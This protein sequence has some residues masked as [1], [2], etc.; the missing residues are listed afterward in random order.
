MG[1]RCRNERGAGAGGRGAVGRRRQGRG[2]RPAALIVDGTGC[3]G[4]VPGVLRG[5][6]RERA[7]TGG[8]RAGGG[9]VSRV[10]RGARPRPRGGLAAP[11]RRLHPD[12]PRIGPDRQ[13]APGRDPHALRLAR[14][15]P[16]PPREP[17]GRGA[18]TEARRH[19]GLDAGPLAGGGEAAPRQHRPRHPGRAPGPGAAQRHALQLR[20]GE[21]G[22]GDETG[23]DYFQQGS[24]GWLR[25]HEKGGKRHDVPAHHRAAEALDKYVEAPSSRSPRRRSSRAWSR[26]RGG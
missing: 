9:A 19:Q 12:P 2:A 24:R 26:R 16:G 5:A 22:P 7:D 11:R 14:R 20:A 4:A 8:V 13:A 6:D 18:G 15:Q 23:Q 3:G 21:R 1:E 25:L 10:V 17:G